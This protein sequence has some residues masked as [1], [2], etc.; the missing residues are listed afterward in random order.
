MNDN[1][2]RLGVYR[3]L[4]NRNSTLSR[5]ALGVNPSIHIIVDNGAVQHHM[6]SILR[7]QSREDYYNRATNEVVEFIRAVQAGKRREWIEQFYGKPGFDLEDGSVI[8]DIWT[9]R[10]PETVLDIYQCDACGRIFIE[11]APHSFAYRPF[12]P[13]EEDWRGTL[14][15]Q[16]PP[17]AAATT[18]P[19]K[20]RR[21]AY[22]FRRSR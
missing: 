21:S 17:A 9:R 6:G 5:Y 14:A 7:E 19:A 4:F 3:S 2:I 15:V 12:N 18:P 20:P 16:L 8:F 10:D 13:E 1:G 22:R 11:R